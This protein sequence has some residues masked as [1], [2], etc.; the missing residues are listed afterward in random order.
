MSF[1]AG[2]KQRVAVAGARALFVFALDAT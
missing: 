2:D 1:L